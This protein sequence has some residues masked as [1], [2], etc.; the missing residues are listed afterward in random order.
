MFFLN[1]FF[2][3]APWCVPV[4]ASAVCTCLAAAEAG[5]P[6]P[7]GHLFATTW[8]WGRWAKGREGTGEGTRRLP[9]TVPLPDASM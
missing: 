8:H 1:Q 3:A 4:D 2:E 9:T 5:S 6:C 7:R